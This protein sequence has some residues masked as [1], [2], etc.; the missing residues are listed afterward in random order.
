[1]KSWKDQ[2]RVR[3]QPSVTGELGEPRAC[4]SRIVVL[5]P[6]K[7]FAEL[8]YHWNKQARQH[9]YA[10]SCPAVS[11]NPKLVRGQRILTARLS[12]EGWL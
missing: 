7:I 4:D 8:L 9:H 12:T 10:E 5:T 1:M 3:V 6:C 11:A 2:V